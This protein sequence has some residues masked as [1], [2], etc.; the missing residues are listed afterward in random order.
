MSDY[1]NP[2][3]QRVLATVLLL[4]GNEFDG[5]AP[6]ELAR[7]LATNPSN[8]TRDLAN[9]ETAGF[10]ERLPTGRWRLGPKLVQI[11]LAFSAHVAKKSDQ[12]DEIRQ[13]YTR[14]PS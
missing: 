13:R 7:A 2:A 8:V 14:L 1:T 5:V 6:V 4:A 3:Q 12:L 10:A 9:L 11:G